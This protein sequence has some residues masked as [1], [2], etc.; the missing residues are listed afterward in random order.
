VVTT[1]V[2]ATQAGACNP[3]SSPA[4]LTASSDKPMEMVGEVTAGEA[5]GVLGWETKKNEQQPHAPLQYRTSMQRQIKAD[6]QA[7]PCTGGKGLARLR[8]TKNR[9]R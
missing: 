9:A 3:A 4:L 5:V 1:G 6:G 8:R 2:N 7:L